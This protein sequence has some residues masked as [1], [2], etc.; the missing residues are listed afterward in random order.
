MFNE[1]RSINQLERSE[2]WF[3]CLAQEDQNSEDSESF[4]DWLTKFL[5]EN[6]VDNLSETNEDTKDERNKW[7]ILYQ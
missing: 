5:S 3:N 2:I 4:D 1:S 7:Y 6:P